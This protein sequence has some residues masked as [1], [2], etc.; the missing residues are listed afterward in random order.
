MLSVASAAIDYC[1]HMGIELGY[2]Q[3][4]NEGDEES[5]EPQGG[6]AEDE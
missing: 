4:S 3:P 5:V 6:E 1:D 2:L